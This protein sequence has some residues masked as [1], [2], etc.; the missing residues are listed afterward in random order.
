MDTNYEKKHREDLESAKDWLA[1][2]K[3]NDN[4]IAIQIIEKFF[5]DLKESEDER[6]RYSLM[7]FL[8]SLSET[9]VPSKEEFRKWWYWL[10]KQGEQKPSWSEEDEKIYQS[11]IDDTVQENQLDDKQINW[12]E[13]LKDRVQPQPKQEWSEEDRKHI[14]NII[15]LLNQAKEEYVRKSGQFPSWI[16]EILWLK[17]LKSQN[18]WKPSEEQ[19]NEVK[20][21]IGITGTN[22]IVLLSLYNDLKSLCLKSLKSQ[23]HWKPSEQN[24]KDLEWCA[25]LV[26]DKMGVGFHRLQVFI[27]ELK[28][29]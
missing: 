28:N 29:L 1:I 22:G 7:S 15:S 14:D 24:I 5:P 6:I 11:I 10:E 4:K 20:N 12:L 26:K 2:A 23:P 16:N 13:S 9:E 3:E 19:L 18:M 17:S 8:N 21:A 25:D 27:D